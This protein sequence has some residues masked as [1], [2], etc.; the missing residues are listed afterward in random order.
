[1]RF[2]ECVLHRLL[3]VRRGRADDDGDP[4]CDGL[5]CSH[6][7]LVG[8]RIAALGAGDQLGFIVWSAHHVPVLHRLAARR[9]R[10][11]RPVAEGWTS[12]RL[13][14]IEPITVAGSLQWRP[15]RR[16]LGVRAFG[17]NAYVAAQAGDD[18]VE[19]HTEATLGHEEVY[20]VLT[21]RATFELDGETLDAPAGT[22]VFL[23]D[24]AVKRHARAEEAGTS[25]LAVGGKPG[26]A[27]TPSAWEAYFAAERH[28]PSGD[29]GA[30]AD[31]LQ[32]ALVEY[33]DHPGV[34]YNLACAEAQCGRLDEALEHL[35]RAVGQSPSF[36]AW[37]RED[38]DLQ[39][40]RDR[41]DT[42]G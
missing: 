30:M 4:E 5:V 34:L 12:V 20:V 35:R 31:E 15:L 37:S 6:E 8:S 13:E 3:G 17:I 16:T 40:L 36:L 7:L 38:A 22:V 21:G 19:E 24:P 39:P 1:M 9:S 10:Y 23:R 11:A 27:F 26:E 33:P 32:E 2:H 14:E 25:V 28:R 41:G 42:W 18:V 29:F